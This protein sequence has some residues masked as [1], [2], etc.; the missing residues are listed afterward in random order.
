M[1][2]H[3]SEGTLKKAKASGIA[4]QFAAMGGNLMG[5]ATVPRR[6]L[7]RQFEVQ[8]DTD[9]DNDSFMDFMER[10]EE[11]SEDDVNIDGKR[12]SPGTA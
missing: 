9:Q 1:L 5:R 6:A 10:N 7:I 12:I 2:T 11:S 4:S 8:Y 3:H